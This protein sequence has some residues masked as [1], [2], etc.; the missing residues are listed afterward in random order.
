MP[1]VR[2]DHQF[3]LGFLYR[4]IIDFVERGQLGAV[5]TASILMKL[6]SR[7]SGREPDLLFVA[8]GHLDRIKPTLI[9]GPADLVVEVMS[10]ESE[11]QDRAVKL[12]EYEAGGV[13]EY[14]LVDSL[15]KEAYFYLLG[16]DGRY[17]LV[18][19]PEDGVYRSRVLED[20]RLRVD[21]LWRMP[22]PTPDAALSELTP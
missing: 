2:V 8:A 20:F 5:L 15:R 6:S 9:D 3:I 11:E 19:M 1:P 21:W 12:A 18:P 22:L 7:P 14:W 13:P 10:P 4:L 16:E 17:H